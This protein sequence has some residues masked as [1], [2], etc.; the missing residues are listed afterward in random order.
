MT[1][2]RSK[3]QRS[4]FKDSQ[5]GSDGLVTSCQVCKYK[6]GKGGR[7]RGG[8]CLQKRK[9]EGGKKFSCS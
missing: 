5:C 4:G 1:I 9:R 2:G 6:M 3:L 8:S 7:E